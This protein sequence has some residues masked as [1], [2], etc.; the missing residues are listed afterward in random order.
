[1][2]VRV[3]VD[4]ELCVGSESCVQLAPGAFTIGE[5]GIAIVADHSAVDIEKLKLAEKSCPSGAIRVTE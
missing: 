1:M 3:E 5:D 4:R 2:T